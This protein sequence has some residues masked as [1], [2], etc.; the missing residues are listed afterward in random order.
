MSEIE[1][2]SKVSLKL[3]SEGKVRRSELPALNT[4]HKHPHS[5]ERVKHKIAK[6]SEIAKK[7]SKQLKLTPLYK[8]IPGPLS[9]INLIITKNELK[10]QD[11][12][13]T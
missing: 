1:T 9:Y 5:L 7:R 8:P 10:S 13:L 6:S 12:K 2:T 4:T 11:I 3:T